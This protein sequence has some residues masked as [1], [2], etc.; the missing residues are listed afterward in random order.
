MNK[1]NIDIT[2]IRIND[3]FRYAGEVFFG[4]EDLRDTSFRK[5]NMKEHMNDRPYVVLVQERFPCFDSED[6]ANED[7]FYQNYYLTTDWAKAKQICEDE[8]AGNGLFPILEPMFSKSKIEERHLPYIYYHGDWNT[9]EIV[10]DKNAEDRVEVFSGPD[11]YLSDRPEPTPCVY[12]PPP[13]IAREF[14]QELERE[15]EHESDAED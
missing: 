15:H 5:Y 1:D 6:S 7:R 12:G 8:A 13:D 14:D 9:M 3:I 4:L 11:F 2:E 10:Q